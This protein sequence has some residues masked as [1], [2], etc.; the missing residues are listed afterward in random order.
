MNY[1]V[2]AESFAEALAQLLETYVKLNPDVKG[3]E[4][5]YGVAKVKVRIKGR[6]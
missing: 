5:D 1:K 2:D 6:K 3:F 4:M